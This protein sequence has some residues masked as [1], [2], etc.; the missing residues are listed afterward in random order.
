MELAESHLADRF[1]GAV[2]PARPLL[3][4]IPLGIHCD[5]FRPDPAA[6]TALRDRLGIAPRRYRLGHHR[7]P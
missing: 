4:V 6:G 1:P 5:D 7:P 2:L 3:P